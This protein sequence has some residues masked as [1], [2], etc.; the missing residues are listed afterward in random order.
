[1]YIYL[2][3]ITY[4]YIFQEIFIDCKFYLTNIEVILEAKVLI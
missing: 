2:K 4:K 1:M 3:K